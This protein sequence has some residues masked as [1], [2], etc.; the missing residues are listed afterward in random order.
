M[1]DRLGMEY[2]RDRL[3]EGE[4]RRDCDDADDDAAGSLLTTINQLTP[5]WVR[6]SLA[7][8]D[9]AKLPG[10]RLSR[11]TSADVQLV[12]AD[13]SLYPTKGRLNFTATA[14]D[15]WIAQSGAEVWMLIQAGPSISS[16]VIATLKA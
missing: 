3:D 15:S 16:T 13:G 11:A 14:I 9:L 6:F 2:S 4:E 5:I 12:L 7:E 10:G 8:A 1:C